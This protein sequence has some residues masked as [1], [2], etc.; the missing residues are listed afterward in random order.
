[1]SPNEMA[2][3]SQRARLRK[4]DQVSGAL[5]LC[6]WLVRSE[7]NW[8]IDCYTE[9]RLNITSCPNPVATPC[10]VRFWLQLTTL[11]QYA[12]DYE[13]VVRANLTNQ[14]D[15]IKRGTT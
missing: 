14:T 2:M 11:N 7:R 13:F 5:C 6:G 9:L 3:R 8:V 4:N 15:M 1:M 12:V 10:Q